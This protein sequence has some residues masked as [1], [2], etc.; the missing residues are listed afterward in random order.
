ML[1]SD[2]ASFIFLAVPK[3][4][5]SSIERALAKYRSP[6]TAKFR[7]HATCQRLKRELPESL[8]QTYFKF[9]FVRN[10]YDVM[11]SWYFYRQR[12]ALA[13]PG[14]PR[15]HLYTGNQTFPEFIAS[16]A[17]NDWMLL[18]LAWVAPPALGDEIQLDFVGR[19]ENLEEDFRFVCDR[20]G[21]PPLKLPTVRASDNDA[22]A[23]SLWDRAS[24]ARV[25]AYFRRDFELF[26]YEMLED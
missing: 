15:H 4:G 8:W 23:S 24:R 17:D 7:K 9:A 11:Q 16:F 20:V 18:Q 10:P 21:I 25:N 14:H 22:S 2:S 5:T 12:P 3:T 19:F 1:I 26:G 13:D 6:L